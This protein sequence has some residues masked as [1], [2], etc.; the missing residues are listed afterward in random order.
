MSRCAFLDPQLVA[1][2]GGIG[3]GT[4]HPHEVTAQLSARTAQQ[5]YG[6]FAPARLPAPPKEREAPSRGLA[7]N[8]GIRTLLLREGTVRP[9][10]EMSS[11]RAM[12]GIRTLLNSGTAFP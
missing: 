10:K 6:A 7:A 12:L 2:I 9:F 1:W 11:V 8:L 5:R 4:T 3:S